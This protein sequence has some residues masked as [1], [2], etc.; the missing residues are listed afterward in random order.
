MSDPSN[1]A[2]AGDAP[3]PGPLLKADRSECLGT[4]VC[5]LTAPD[6]FTQ[7]DDEGLVVILDE[8]PGPDLTDAAREAVES[9]PSGALSLVE[10]DDQ[11]PER[12]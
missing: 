9:C 1:S 3:Q 7:D 10:A 12:P 5:V 2:A 4:G 6:L 8:S 11:E